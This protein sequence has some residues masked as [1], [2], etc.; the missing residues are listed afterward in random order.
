VLVAK[1]PAFATSSSTGGEATGVPPASTT[2]AVT[3]IALTTG[4]SALLV[5][6]L[7][8]EQGMQYSKDA[9]IMRL[10]RIGATGAPTKVLEYGWTNYASTNGGTTEKCS[11]DAPSPGAKLPAVLDVRCQVHHERYGGNGP[12]DVTSDTERV[13]HYKW[14]G[15][16]YTAP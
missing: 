3:A 8:N 1:L 15:K 12:D 5:S 4:E 10:F 14:D 2:I 9:A 16:S 13:D 11:L 6:E 7:S